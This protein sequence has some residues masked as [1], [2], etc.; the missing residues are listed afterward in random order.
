MKIQEM[1]TII[2]QS[3][4]VQLQ[5]GFGYRNLFCDNICISSSLTYANTV[6]LVN[7]LEKNEYFTRVIVDLHNISIFV[8]AREYDYRLSIDFV[9]SLLTELSHKELELDGFKIYTDD[10]ANYLINHATYHNTPFQSYEDYHN[11]NGSYKVYYCHNM[12]SVFVAIEQKNAVAYHFVR[13]NGVSFNCGESAIYYH[14]RTK[15]LEVL[16]KLK[17]SRDI[18]IKSL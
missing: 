11:N 8:S 1:K 15:I 2:N 9:A 17:D 5:T 12:N 10:I 14:D 6:T 16:P 18:D 3:R 13:V 7:Y 4:I